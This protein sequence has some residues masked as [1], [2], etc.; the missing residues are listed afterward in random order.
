MHIA[1][2]TRL[3]NQLI[4]NLDGLDT[5]NTITLTDDETRPTHKWLWHKPSDTVVMLYVKDDNLVVYIGE[6]A[7]RKCE[8][9]NTVDGIAEL[10]MA[11]FNSHRLQCHVDE[12]SVTA[13]RNYLKSRNSHID[14]VRDICTV[15][16]ENNVVVAKITDQ[17]S[18]GS[19]TYVSNHTPMQFEE[20]YK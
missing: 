13:V 6:D 5:D 19:T 14:P 12:V 15:T 18:G 1:K 3:Y 17:V 20:A 7:D 9:F 8:S 10:L 2:G 11:H 4:A 16:L